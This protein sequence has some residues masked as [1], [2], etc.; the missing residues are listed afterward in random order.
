MRSGA[1]GRMAAGSVVA[2]TAEAGTGACGPSGRHATYGGRGAGGDE[3]ARR[4]LVLDTIDF[5]GAAGAA[6]I[7]GRAGLSRGAEDPAVP[8][9]RLLFQRRG[10]AM[11]KDDGKK[12][13]WHEDKA[14]PPPQSVDAGAASLRLSK[15][16]EAKQPS[17]SI[18]IAR[19]ASA[20]SQGQGGTRT[21]RRARGRLQQQ[22]QE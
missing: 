1:A 16:L 17:M 2:E 8:M 10:Q 4:Y 5:G 18:T 3:G 6:K 13:R 20:A 22:Q 7:Q 12:K 19:A 11:L 9:G 21:Y 14:A 15:I